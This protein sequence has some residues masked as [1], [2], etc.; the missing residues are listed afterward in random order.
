[1]TRSPDAVSGTRQRSVEPHR[2]ARDAVTIAGWLATGERLTRVV[3]R[4]GATSWC[5]CA[6]ATRL[7]LT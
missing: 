1:M 4:S 2:L 5:W 6:A 7:W 3:V